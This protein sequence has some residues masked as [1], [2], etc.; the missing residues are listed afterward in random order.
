MCKH[1]QRHTGKHPP[2]PLRLVSCPV[3]AAVWM[4]ASGPGGGA[5]LGV[6]SV[7]CVSGR[8]TTWSTVTTQPAHTQT[9]NQGGKIKYFV[10]M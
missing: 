4:G 7:L 3:A 1:R 10:R 9:H 6:G 2:A 5:V 8:G